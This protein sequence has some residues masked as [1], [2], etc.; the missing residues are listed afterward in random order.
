MLN[1]RRMTRVSEK[2]L[3]HIITS[4]GHS[5]KPIRAT[6]KTIIPVDS[7]L[8]GQTKYKISKVQ[9]VLCVSYN[10]KFTTSGVMQTSDGPTIPRTRRVL[11]RTGK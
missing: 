1:T 11:K 9:S 8:G 2:N 4:D 3:R 7:T 10:A 6:N 5:K